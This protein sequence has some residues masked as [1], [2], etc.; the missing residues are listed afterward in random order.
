MTGA[1]TWQSIQHLRGL[2]ALS[3]ALFHACQWSQVNFATGQAGV[4]V[5]F[6]ISGF[7]MW[8]ATSGRTVR[9]MAFF[10]RR[11]V[12]VAPLYW[13]ITLALAAAVTLVPA[14]FPDLSADPRHV[15]LSLAFI[16]HD[17]PAGQP[18]PL[19]APGWTLNYE[20]VFYL[21][22]GA[23]LLLPEPRR[24]FA[25]TFALMVL[26]FAGFAWPPAYQMLLNPLF[27]EFLAGVWLGRMAQLELLP[28]RSM[29]WLLLGGGTALFT[30]IQLVNMDWDLWRPM[31]WGAPAMMVV[32]GAISIE[33][34]GGWRD[35]RGL[36]ILGD[37]SYS[38]YL[39][40]TLSIGALAMTIGA[41]NPPIFI[42]LAM[43]VATV[44][45]LACWALVE[46]PL[47]NRLRQWVA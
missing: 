21:V 7:V 14:R 11:L 45:G 5:F 31:V 13:L 3:V 46:R 23:L 27:L 1:R 16:Q 17:N 12:R 36:K 33:A 47:L 19:L 43:I 6:V 44:S 42:P 40:H 38:I 32:A 41:W 30:L 37:A 20:A 35:L 28:D 18:F 39:V 34:D 10:A 2:A 25:L 26:A 9:P 4:D 24:L 8:T 15:L 22:F 29:G